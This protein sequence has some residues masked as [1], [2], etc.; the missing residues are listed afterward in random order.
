MQWSRLPH[1]SRPDARGFEAAEDPARRSG[2][3]P[4]LEQ[5]L[6]IRITD[7][8]QRLRLLQAQDDAIAVR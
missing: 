3:L 1:I 6:H 4:N 8:R 5:M 7:D 2:G